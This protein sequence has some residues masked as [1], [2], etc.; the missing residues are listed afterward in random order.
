MDSKELSERVAQL[1]EAGV[2]DGR[3]LA[4]GTILVFVIRYGIRPIQYQY[5]AIRARGRWHL[6]GSGQAVPRDA[7]W[8]AV[9]KWLTDHDRVIEQVS[10]VTRLVDYAHGE[11]MTNRRALSQMTELEENVNNPTGAGQVGPRTPGWP[12][13]SSEDF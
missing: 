13:M 2:P 8:G 12:P 7:G 11:V 9:E 10:R 4:D 5:V 1:R 6:T 3:K